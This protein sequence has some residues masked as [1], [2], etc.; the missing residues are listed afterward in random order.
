MEEGD[1]EG[2][3]EELFNLQMEEVSLEMRLKLLYNF[4]VAEGKHNL[5]IIWSNDISPF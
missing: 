1:D 3:I 4:R 2:V 5:I